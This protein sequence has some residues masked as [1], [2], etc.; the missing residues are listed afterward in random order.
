MN[1]IKIKIEEDVI[2]YITKM[3]CLNKNCKHNCE[4]CFCN[5]KNIIINKNGKCFNFD[6][7]ED[8]ANERLNR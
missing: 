6:E 1:D 8:N 2:N 7:I 5:L 3:Q 4:E